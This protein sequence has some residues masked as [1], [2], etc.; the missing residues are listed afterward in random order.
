MLRLENSGRR[1]NSVIWFF[2]EVTTKRR[3]WL[4]MKYILS[5]PHTNNC[6]LFGRY[7]RMYRFDEAKSEVEYFVVFIR[8]YLHSCCCSVITGFQAYVDE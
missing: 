1:Q 3:G 7:R 4:M 5:Y 6:H 2:A 8:F